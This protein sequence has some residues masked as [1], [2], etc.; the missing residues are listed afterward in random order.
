LLPY[1]YGVIY[2]TITTVPEVVTT[3][4]RVLRQSRKKASRQNQKGG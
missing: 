1:L 3:F 2:G 4:K